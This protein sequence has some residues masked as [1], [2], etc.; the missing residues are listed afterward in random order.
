VRNSI[1]W[2]SDSRACSFFA[3]HR[4][5]K[6][7]KRSA[8]ERVAR[9]T[10]KATSDRFAPLFDKERADCYLPID[11]LRKNALCDKKK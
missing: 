10:T 2:Q 9:E 5:V 4:T 6:G 1:S 8:I 11:I 7:G 3:F